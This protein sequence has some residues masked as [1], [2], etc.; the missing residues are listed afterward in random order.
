[1]KTGSLLLAAP[2]AL[3][4]CASEAPVPAVAPAAPPAPTSNRVTFPSEAEIAAGQP[5]RIRPA[6]NFGLYGV[7]QPLPGAPSCGV[8]QQGRSTRPLPVASTQGAVTPVFNLAGRC[9]REND[10]RGLPF[11]RMDRAWQLPQGIYMQG[12]QHE[13]LLPQVGS[14]AVCA[15]RRAQP[16]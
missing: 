3:L 6:A 8:L 9:P 7:L 5:I 13:C 11:L 16:G 1:M 12:A 2:F 14:L 4:A 15:P 10:G